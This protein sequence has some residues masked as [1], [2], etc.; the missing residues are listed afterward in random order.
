[1]FE[2]GM[3]RWPVTT[4]G[5]HEIDDDEDGGGHAQSIAE[6]DQELSR[7]VAIDDRALPARPPGA[8]RARDAREA[9]KR[10]QA[11]RKELEETSH[12]APPGG[13]RRIG[14]EIE[15]HDA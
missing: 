10:Q 3:Q 6:V 4:Q 1:M 12:A 15:E 14:C 11:S 13:R 9:A 8:V 5:L 2:D 7:D